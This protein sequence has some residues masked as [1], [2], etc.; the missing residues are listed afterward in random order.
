[1][2][3]NGETRFVREAQFFDRLA[4]HKVQCQLCPLSC[5]LSDGKRGHCGVRE[6]RE[7]TLFTLVYGQL[8]AAHIDPLEKKPLFHYLPGTNAFSIATAGCNVR[9]SFCQ[10]AEIAQARPEEIAADFAS[11]ELVASLARQSGCPTI[12][13]TYTEPTVYAE[14]AMDTADAGH[15]MGIGS[16]AISNGYIGAEARQQLYGRMDAVKIDLKAF[17]EK[18]YR[19]VVGAQLKP[20]LETLVA[21]KEMG[22]WVEVVYLVV[23]TLN[24]SDE[25]LRG[26][27]HWIAL[28]LGPDVPLHFSQFHPD[29]ELRHLPRTP[30]VTLERAKAIADAEG[31]NYVYIGNIPG[32]P[33]QNTHCPGCGKVLVERT[34]FTAGKM[35]VREDN[36]CPF[37]HHTVAGVW[38]L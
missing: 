17:S 23:P 31:L 27:A 9:C 25:E 13:Y 19:S 20:V 33:A 5:V 2:P 24:D 7:G 18:F 16:V 15:A 30:L 29:H 28:N 10:N 4:S 8:C 3:G 22:K 37:C 12:A 36:T 6:N 35:L 21:L 11:P 26:L 32:H 38:R 1:L 14:Y 34:G